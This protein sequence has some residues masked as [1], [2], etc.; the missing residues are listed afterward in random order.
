M[1][2]EDYDGYDYNYDDLLENTDLYEVNDE[3]W[4]DEIDE[5]DDE[6]PS[7]GKNYYPE[8]LEEEDD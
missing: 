1:R 2:Y 4:M 5:Q 3:P 8:I 7:Y 6:V